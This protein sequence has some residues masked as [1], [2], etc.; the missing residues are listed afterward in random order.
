MA[1]CLR[2]W[3]FAFPW[4][5]NHQGFCANCASEIE[6]DLAILR[7]ENA[8]QKQL[9]HE[10]AMRKA[11]LERQAEE[12]RLKAE[13]EKRKLER[14]QKEKEIF[15]RI[16][17]FNEELDMIWENKVVIQLSDEPAVRKYVKDLTFPHIT[18]ITRETNISK[19][20]P[21]VFID[22]ETTGIRIQGN[23]IIEVSAIRFENSF[24]HPSSCFTSLTKPPKKIPPD[25]TAI[26]GITNEMVENSPSFE[27]IAESFS[28]Y[29]S[30]CN[31][32]GHNLP[33]DLKFL[34]CSGAEF[35]SKVR[36]YDTLE[37]AQR[38]FVRYVDV[39][40][41]KLDSL[42]NRFGIYR[43]NAHRSLSDCFATSYVFRGLIRM[44]TDKKYGVIE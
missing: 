22:V 13:E 40:D 23:S 35:S 19:L 37:L 43:D 11:E 16:A 6:I 32:V 34:L 3:K 27:Q 30:G 10:A 20:F 26:N 14:E 44:L 2:C 41:Y 21:I 12:K 24:N 31:V 7:A 25:A 5:L 39:P 28:N 18:N 29:I 36:Y 1:R 33:F 9:A 4:K 17:V 42:L 8:R 15:E 38:A